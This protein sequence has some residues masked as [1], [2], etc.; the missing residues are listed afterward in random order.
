MVVSF[1]VLEF[2]CGSSC[3]VLWMSLWLC[4]VVVVVTMCL[5][6]RSGSA[7]CAWELAVKVR[8]EHCH[9]ALTVE[10]WRGTLPSRTCS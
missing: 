8:R 4:V 10:V 3:C 7:Q 1:V 6:L 2:V 9:A 5:W